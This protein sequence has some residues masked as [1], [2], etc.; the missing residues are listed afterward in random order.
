MESGCFSIGELS[1]MHEV[2]SAAQHYKKLPLVNY[3]CPCCYNS[4]WEGEWN[5]LFM[6]VQTRSNPRR[7]KALPLRK[8]LTLLIK[9]GTYVNAPGDGSVQGALSETVKHGN[10]VLN[11]VKLLLENDAG[12]NIPGNN[13]LVKAVKPGDEGLKVVQIFLDRGVR[14]NKHS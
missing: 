11:I 9:H 4:K 1:Q 10:G 14:I 8:W 5:F 3:H 6:D 12:I 7:E 2:D 13:I